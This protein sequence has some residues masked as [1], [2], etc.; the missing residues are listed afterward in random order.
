MHQDD[1]R[2]LAFEYMSEGERVLHNSFHAGNYPCGCSI[3]YLER[4]GDHYCASHL[5][6]EDLMLE[7]ANKELL[8]K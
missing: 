8:D 7:L 1:R 5:E 6:E 4:G 3:Y 2:D